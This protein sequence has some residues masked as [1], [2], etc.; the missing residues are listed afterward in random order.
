MD[1][2]L[3]SNVKILRVLYAVYF[4][5]LV[6]VC[7]LMFNNW[8]P[9]KL[10]FLRDFTVF[11]CMYGYLPISAIIYGS[12]CYIKTEDIII[13]SLLYGLWYV[14]VAIIAFFF[15]MIGGAGYDFAGTNDWWVGV[16]LFV[17]LSVDLFFWI[18]L[19]L[20]VVLSI[21]SGLITKLIVSKK[22]AKKVIQQSDDI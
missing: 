5:L 16:S 15:G 18:K 22:R 12:L 14:I 7:L 9:S 3:E 6:I 4:L 19:P 17:F 20:L 13:P 10:N 21:V 2:R 1:E 11:L 8:L